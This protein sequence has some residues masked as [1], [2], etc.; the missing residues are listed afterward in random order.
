YGLR[1]TSANRF[2]RIVVPFVVGWI[3]IY[4]IT[5]FLTVYFR[6]DFQRSWDFILSGWFLV[7]AHPLHLWFLEYLI[8]LYVLAGIAVAA[9]R[10]LVPDKV[11]ILLT[12]GFRS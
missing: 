5:M 3:I 12:R 6:S 1:R 9:V 2:W 4:P 8:V 7:H 11:K 10:F